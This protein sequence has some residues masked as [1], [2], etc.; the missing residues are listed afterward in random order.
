ML[1]VVYSVLWMDHW[2][3]SLSQIQSPVRYYRSMTDINN[4]TNDYFMHCCMVYNKFML[5]YYNIFQI[6]R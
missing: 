5:I 3:M 6:L 2:M 1:Q 4:N